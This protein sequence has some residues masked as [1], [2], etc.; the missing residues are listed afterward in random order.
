MMTEFSQGDLVRIAGYKEL[1]LVVSKNAYIKSTGMI[2]VSPVLSRCEEGPLHIA[3]HGNKGSTGTAVC[4][5]IKLM[6]PSK[7][8]IRT[9]DRIPYQELMNISDAIQGIFEYD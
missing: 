7:R 5:Q 2:H 1:F 9:E 3:V 8:G 6:D 4:E